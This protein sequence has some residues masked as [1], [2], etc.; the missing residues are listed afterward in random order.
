M[1]IIAAILVLITGLTAGSFPE[2]E[3]AGNSAYTDDL[4]AEG[5]R[6][7]YMDPARMMSVGGCVLER[8]AAY[9]YSLLVEA[10]RK[11]GVRLG[12]EDCYRSWSQQ[13]SAYNRRCPIIDVPIYKDNGAAGGVVHV[14]TKRA[15]VC[16]GPPTAQAGRSNHGWG[17]A[18]DFTD[19][20]G[21]LTCYDNEYYWMK[22]HAHHFGWVHPGWAA[23]GGPNAEPWHWEFAGVTDP[24][25][26][27]Y[28]SSPAPGTPVVIEAAE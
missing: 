4:Q 14:G 16:S 3:P 2:Y 19:G 27:A 25:L 1:P 10:A 12:W 8:D 15:R 26:V 20:S 9:T 13:N 11:D 5:Y 17:R 18:V 21:T 28:T 7:G 6:N 23:C 24:T 22:Q